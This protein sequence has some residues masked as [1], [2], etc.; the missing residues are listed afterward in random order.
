MPTTFSKPCRISK[1][2]RHIEIPCNSKNSLFRHFLA[3]WGAFNNIQP[4]YWRTLGHIKAYWGIIEAYWAKFRIL[5]LFRYF[6]V[7]WGAFNN[8]QPFY[9]RTLGHIKAY[10]GIIEAYWAKF[11]ILCDPYINNYATSTTLAHLEH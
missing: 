7:H 8:I 4:F 3:H 11:R 1:M 5:C 2:M 9:W 10:S 6:L